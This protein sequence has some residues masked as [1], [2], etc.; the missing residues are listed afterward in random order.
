MSD[1]LVIAHPQLEQSCITRR[2]LAAAGAAH[3]EETA[4]AR[5]TEHQPAD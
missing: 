1:I 2:L 4:D 5:P 3:G